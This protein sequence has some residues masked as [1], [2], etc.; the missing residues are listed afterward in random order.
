MSTLLKIKFKET[1]NEVSI[2][3][4]AFIPSIGDA[5]NNEKDGI[6]RYFVTFREFYYY[7]D[8]L[9]IIINAS[10]TK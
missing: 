9:I 7:E 3:N 6:N 1:E 8:Y 4:A 5:V 2:K 10:K